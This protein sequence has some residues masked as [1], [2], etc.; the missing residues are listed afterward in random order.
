LKSGDIILI[1]NFLG[2]WM[3]I[4][5]S[6][7]QVPKFANSKKKEKSNSGCDDLVMVIIIINIVYI[8]SFDANL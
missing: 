3:A 2:Y 5:E 6:L 7:T 1:S 8:W 4:L